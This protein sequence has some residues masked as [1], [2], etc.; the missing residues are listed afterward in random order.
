MAVVVDRGAL[1]REMAENAARAGAEFLLKT[2]VCGIEGNTVLVRGAQQ[3]GPIPYRILI[4]ADGP[5]G[6]IARH[7]GMER[8]KVFLSGIQAEVLQECDPGIVEIYPDASPG[9]F[10][11]MIPAGPGRARVGLCGRADVP[12]IFSALRN[13]FGSPAVHLVTG[14]LPLGIMPKTYGHRALFVGDAAGFA[15]PTSGGGVYTGVR[16]ARHAAAVAIAACMAGRYD[17]ELLSAYE[18]RWQEDFGRELAIGFRLFEMRQRMSGEDIDAVIRAL[19]DPEIVRIIEEHG[20]MDRPSALM[21]KIFLRPGVIRLLG[22][23][24]QAGLKSFL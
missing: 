11:W 15:K 9:F 16:S 6:T 10:G 13:R 3:Q 4:A 14:T 21:K 20:D 8:P 24:V 17:D 2:T 12:R 5:R 7:L 19:T 22:P 18:Q 1:D 23:L